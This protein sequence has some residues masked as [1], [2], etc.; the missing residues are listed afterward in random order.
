TGYNSVIYLA[1][2]SGI[3]QEYYEAAMI[4]GASKM[5]QTWFITIPLIRPVIIILSLLAVGRIFNSDF[6]MFYNIPM[7]RSQL[8]GV[9]EVLD[10]FIYRAMRGATEFGMPVAASLFQSLVGFITIMVANFT[11][12]R[13]DP[14]S[15][16]F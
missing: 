12:R 11:V 14:E 3:S 15:S 9:T 1:A 13:I 10:T 4:D 16:L 8:F 2:I 7:G 5:Q 6:G